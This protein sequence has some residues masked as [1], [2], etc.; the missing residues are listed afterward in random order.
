MVTLRATRGF[1]HRTELY[2]FLFY[3]D[4][5]KDK[6]R[7]ISPV[8]LGSKEDGHSFISLLMGGGGGD[9]R[10]TEKCISPSTFHF[11]L[12]ILIKVR[13]T[14]ERTSCHPSYW[15]RSKTDRR[16]NYVS[17]YPSNSD[18]HKTDTHVSSPYHFWID[19]RQTDRRRNL[20][21]PR[22][23]RKPINHTSLVA[24]VTLTD[25]H[26]SVRNRCVIDHFGGVF[27][28]S[29]SRLTFLLV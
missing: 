5:Q 11:I 17:F 8:I 2:L 27:V 1:N 25:R 18:P 7:F 3:Q 26:K 29:L 20:F 4:G 16:T 12:H 10:Q 13:Q 6:L 19:L 9:F 24:V 21:H 28:L 14:D 23:T 15:N 22:W